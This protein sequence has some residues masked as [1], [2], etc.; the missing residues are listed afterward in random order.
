MIYSLPYLRLYFTSEKVNN[1]SVWIK[2]FI[3]LTNVLF[4]AFASLGAVHVAKDINLERAWPLLCGGRGIS[5]GGR[6]M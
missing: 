2:L 5:E 6:W 1:L 3:D 4:S